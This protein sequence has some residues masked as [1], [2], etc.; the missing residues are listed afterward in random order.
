MLCFSN[1]KQHVAIREWD[2]LCK[3]LKEESKAGFRQTPWERSALQGTG[4][5][6]PHCFSATWGVEAMPLTLRSLRTVPLVSPA[7]LD[8]AH[9]GDVPWSR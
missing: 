2:P 4:H 3:E 8:L 6:S 1:S 7:T 9:L 5:G